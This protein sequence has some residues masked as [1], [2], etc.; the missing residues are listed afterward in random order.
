MT[1]LIYF[2]L[3]EEA[4]MSAFDFDKLYVFMIYYIYGYYL[5]K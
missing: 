4:R 5:I 1:E 2:F 3:V